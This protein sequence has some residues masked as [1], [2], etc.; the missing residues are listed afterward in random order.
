M[1]TLVAFGDSITEGLNSTD[2]A[3]RRWTDRLAVRLFDQNKPWAI[4]NMGIS[5]NK[6]LVDQAG[7]SGL[8]RFDRDVLAQAGVTHATVLLG[9]NDINGGANGPDLIAGQR[10]FIARAHDR[11]HQDHRLHADALRRGCRQRH[12]ECP[13]AA[14]LLYPQLGRV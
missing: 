12:R 1:P 11:G 2:N 7:P 4:A 13:A 8:A 3:N 5:G 9:I 10:Q 6:V 14:Q